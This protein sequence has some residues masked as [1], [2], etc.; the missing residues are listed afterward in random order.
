[1]DPR[2]DYAPADIITRARA[3]GQGALDEHQSKRLLSGFGIPVCREASASSPDEAAAAARALGFPVVV[4]ACGPSLM[5]KTE[6]GAVALDLRNEEEVRAAARRLVA[7]PGAESVLVQE[8]VPGSRELICGFTRRP[9]FGPCVVFGI[10]GTLAEALDDVALRLAPLT[11]DDA[12]AMLA[13][14][15]L[16]GLLGPFRGSRAVDHDQLAGILVALGDAAMRLPEVAQVDLNPLKVRPDGSLVAVDALVVLAPD[17][18]LLLPPDAPPGTAAAS[19]RPLFEPASVVVVGASA[20]PGKPGHDV[21]RNILAN[22]YPGRLYLV[23]PAGGNILGLPV[24]RSVA[25]LPEAPDLAVVVVPAA[26]STQVLR[27]CAARGIRHAVVSAGGFAEFDA[28][29]AGIQRELQDMISATGMRVLGPNTAGHTSTPQKFTS[30]FFPLGRVRPGKVSYITQTGNFCTHTMK[31]ILSSEHFGVAR[32]VGLGNA[33]DIDECDALEYVAADPETAAVVMYLESFHRPRRFLS[34][35]RE[36]RSHKPLVVLK[37][38]SSEARGARRRWRIL[39]RWPRR[40]GW[41]RG[42]S[43]RRARSGSPSTGT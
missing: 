36:M 27:D 23:N 20:T 15:R 19:L 14:I 13:E 5:H 29:G 38:G 31:R 39:P 26:R 32:V 12:A 3:A 8:M 21:V 18:A 4:K 6:S 2:H 10:G 9:G 28:A 34:L 35:A 1:M 37:S 16:A 33:I 17:A 41:S 40:T 22:E 42:C 24:H 25:D 7:I 11:R 30:G 43:A